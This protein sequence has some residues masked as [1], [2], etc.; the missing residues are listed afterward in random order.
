MNGYDLLQIIGEAREDFVLETVASCTGGERIK[1]RLPVRKSVLIAAVIAVTLVLAGCVAVFLRLQDLSIAQETYVPKL[2]PY[3]HF[4]E[5]TE[6]TRDV[7]T[8][9][10]HS[11]SPVQQAAKE[12]YE[13]TQSYDP[14][15]ALMTN[16]QDDPSIANNYEYIYHCYTQEMV[17]KVDEIAETYGLNLLQDSLTIQDW[18][19]QVALE[20]MQIHGLFREDAGV[21][22][23]ALSG[24]FYFPQ[25]FSLN[26]RFQLTGEDA[27][28]EKPVS[29]RV[30]Y[31]RKDYMVPPSY[32]EVD[33][34]TYEQWNHTAADGTELL[35]ALSSNGT[36]LILADREDAVIG[37]RL[38][39][40]SNHLAS[41]TGKAPTREVVE[42]LAKAF[43]YTITP[44][45]R[46]TEA[47]KTRLAQIDA[48]YWES[49][50]APEPVAYNDFASYIRENSVRLRK[51]YYTYYDVNADGEEDLLISSGDG[52][53]TS[54]VSIIDGAAISWY[55]G[56]PCAL[57]EN[58]GVMIGF[59]D[60]QQLSYY[61][62]AEGGGY[63]K[64]PQGEENSY[65]EYLFGLY[66]YLGE[67]QR[68]DSFDGEGK[69]ISGEEAQSLQDQFP[70]LELDWTPV[71][72]HPLENGQTVAEHLAQLDVRL[73]DEEVTEKYRELAGSLIEAIDYCRYRLIDIN[74]D[75][76]LD[77]LLSSDSLADLFPDS[78]SY[79][80]SAYTYRYG[81]LLKLQVSDF[82]LCAEGVLEA[83]GDSPAPEGGKRYH[84]KYLYLEDE[85]V[86]VL[87]YVVY[88]QGPD[89]WKLGETEEE[90][91]AQ[92]AQAIREK[93]PRIDQG[94]KPIEELMD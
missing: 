42:E 89:L 74:N 47:M 72:E 81:T 53:F 37:I 94:M 61:G 57:L 39:I 32:L 48:A 40:S 59:P 64:I 17:D 25:N 76:V 83:A 88:D 84:H 82:Y 5:P 31:S 34:E 92:E 30:F 12:W 78:S 29:A 50:E 71:T 16:L 33:L 19:H 9:Y 93:Y 58:G 80:W 91:S 15:G 86:R 38:T 22:V 68:S 41:E 46:D 49:K 85:D 45:V 35:L 18:Q 7:L 56:G 73:S 51:S 67:W 23:K 77:L 54:C 1:K 20:E 62:P 14:E 65:G 52:T 24:M 36:A 90:I 70:I 75:G 79:Y 13:F 87:D 21:A 69:P 3:G 26:V 63:L 43:D 66:Y 27:L 6:Q 11:G 4:A 55:E 44:E 10:A 2:D 28:W 8:L 60:G